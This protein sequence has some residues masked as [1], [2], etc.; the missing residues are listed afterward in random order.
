MIDDR[1]FGYET[2]KIRARSTEVKM[3]GQAHFRTW[4]FGDENEGTLE[5]R[6]GVCNYGRDRLSRALAALLSLRPSPHKAC[7]GDP[8][9]LPNPSRLL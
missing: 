6:N 1:C 2:L 8:T 5:L 3:R 9:E 7:I 4:E